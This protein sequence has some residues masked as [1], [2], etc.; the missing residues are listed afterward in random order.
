[1][2]LAMRLLMASGGPPR[3]VYVGGRCSGTVG[4]T[5]TH[6][7]GFGSLSGGV[8]SAAEEGD[9]VIIFVAYG[10]NGIDLDMVCL[11]SGFVKITDIYQFDSYSANLGIF[12]KIM[13]ATPDESAEVGGVT[14]L[15]TQG[16]TYGVSV[17]RNVD[18]GTPFDVATTT[19]TNDNQYRADPPAITPVTPGSVVVCVGCNAVSD[20]LV[21]SKFTAP[22]LEGFLTA[23]GD[24]TIDSNIGF[25]Y[26]RWASGEFNPNAFSTVATAATGS[27][28]AASIAIRPAT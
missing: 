10:T 1:M 8:G 2:N 3:P 26:Y 22:Q 11:T 23:R 12:Y 5:D 27:W 19:A 13:T 21:N 18:Q 28:C 7:V 24:D 9:L 4:T 16:V 17:W 14:S 15:S 6:V 20:T 25:G